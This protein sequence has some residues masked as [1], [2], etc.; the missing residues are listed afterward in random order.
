MAYRVEVQA[1]DELRRLLLT[2]LDLA[3]FQNAPQTDGIT[4]AELIRL[5]A[6]SPSQAR[7]LL[8]T[9]GYFSPQVSVKRDD[10]DD[11]TP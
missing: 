8:E 11:Q 3:R 9:E 10:P 7:S 5:A 4:N 2:H 6:A 1:P